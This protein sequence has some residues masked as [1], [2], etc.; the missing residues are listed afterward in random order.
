MYLRRSTPPSL[1]LD[2]CIFVIFDIKQDDSFLKKKDKISSL[3]KK[4]KDGSN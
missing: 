1:S 2:W 4:K 3:K